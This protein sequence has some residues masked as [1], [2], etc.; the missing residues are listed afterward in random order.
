MQ[1][2]LQAS[3][4]RVVPIECDLSREDVEARFEGA[5]KQFVSVQ[6]QQLE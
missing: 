2:A 6:R 5:L 4:G 1:N 3:G